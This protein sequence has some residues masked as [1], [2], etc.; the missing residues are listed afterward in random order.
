[1]AV[2]K[3]SF[4]IAISC[5]LAGF[6]ASSLA[7][8]ADLVKARL[9][10]DLV[11]VD[12]IQDVRDRYGNSLEL[13]SGKGRVVKP[14]LEWRTYDPYEQTI[15]LVENELRIYDPDLEQLIIKDITDEAGNVPLHILRSRNIK[16]GDFMVV[17]EEADA[18]GAKYFSLSPQSEQV[19]FSRIEIK[20]LKEQLQS[21]RLIGVSGEVTEINFSNFK[22]LDREDSLFEISVPEGTDIVEG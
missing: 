20:I 19:L 4:L 5:A 17:E 16:L 1:M 3:F 14:S 11:K 21:I 6:S 2:V 15:M 10:F 8:E 7:S 22:R 9:N 12:F 18:S 13:S